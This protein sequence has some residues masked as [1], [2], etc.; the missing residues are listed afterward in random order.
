MS[1]SGEDIRVE[2]YS[3]ELDIAGSSKGIAHTQ[4]IL[5]T[6]PNLRQQMLFLWDN[7]NLV[8]IV[9]S[10]PFKPR[11]SGHSVEIALYFGIARAKS[12]RATLRPETT[13]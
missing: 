12:G 9:I 7:R 4:P 8:F 3:D 5:H 6:H 1:F 11:D 13:P 2:D 10:N